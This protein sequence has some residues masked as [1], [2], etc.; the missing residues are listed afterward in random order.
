M[1]EVEHAR[2]SNPVEIVTVLADF[3]FVF[4]EPAFFADLEENEETFV[5]KRAGWEKEK[6]LPVIDV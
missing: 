4:P 1:M 3:N 5:L 2:Q 6:D